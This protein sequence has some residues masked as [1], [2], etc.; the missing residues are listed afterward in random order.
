MASTLA[1]GTG[2]PTAGA[3]GAGDRAEAL[4]E[5]PE[6]EGE[7]GCLQAPMTKTKA[8][9]REVLRSMARMV[10]LK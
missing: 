9:G 5:G 8:R 2:M 7:G 6:P 1:A 4:A 3:D 10:V